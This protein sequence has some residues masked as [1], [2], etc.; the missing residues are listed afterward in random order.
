MADDQDQ[1]DQQ[2]DD[3]QDDTQGADQQ[4]T[5][6]GQDTQ[7]LGDAGKQ[8]LDRMK[9]ERNAARKQLRE[10]TAL[11]LSVDDI[12]ALQQAKPADDA[13]DP[14]KIRREAAAEAQAKA[15]ARIVRAEVKAAAAGKLADPADAHRF[16]DLSQF[17]V[18]D[19]GNVDSS[20][21]SDAIDDLLQSKPYLAAQQGQRRFQGSA[22]AGA[23]RDK[24]LTLNDRIV[25]AEKAGDHRAV[26][27]LKARQT[28]AI[29]SSNT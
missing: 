13:P 22:D 4:Q 6:D 17:E 1:T 21:I 27:R 8:A 7:Q 15:N 11:G 26:A 9:A 24:P 20:E 19:D 5:D 23:R 12:R 25:E 18:D 14:D 28:L 2:A 16:L 29:S 3:T 10:F